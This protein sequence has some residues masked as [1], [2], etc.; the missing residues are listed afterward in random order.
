MFQV[1]A[2]CADI[3]VFPI[4]SILPEFAQDKKI[5]QELPVLGDT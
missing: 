1:V 2:G 5:S 3:P 4:L